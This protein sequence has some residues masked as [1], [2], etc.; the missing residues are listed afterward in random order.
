MVESA[1]RSFDEL[2]AFPVGKPVDFGPMFLHQ[3]TERGLGVELKAC[4]KSGQHVAPIFW[5]KPG[6]DVFQ[7][8]VGYWSRVGH[9]S[10][11]CT[12]RGQGVSTSTKPLVPEPRLG[13]L[14]PPASLP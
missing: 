12:A 8:G 2:V 5:S 13:A 7:S 4:V 1:D 11:R 9:E 10:Q 14:D 3:V 6:K